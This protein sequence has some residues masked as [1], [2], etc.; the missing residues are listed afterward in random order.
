ME[1]E[2]AREP[3]ETKSRAKSGMDG[4]KLYLAK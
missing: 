4:C 2:M 1:S 3:G